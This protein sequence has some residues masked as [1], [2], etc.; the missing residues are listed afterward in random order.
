VL[1]VLPPWFFTK[2]SNRDDRAQHHMLLPAT[3]EALRALAHITG[4]PAASLAR[5]LPAF[6]TAGVLCQRI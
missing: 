6:G 2:T 5:A 4:T 3:A 1:T